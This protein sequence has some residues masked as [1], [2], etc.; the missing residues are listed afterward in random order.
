MRK[1]TSR[2]KALLSITAGAAAGVSAQTSW[3][4]PFAR[5]WRDSFL[6]HWKVTKDYTLAV[7]DAM[8]A[9]GFRF[10]PTDVQRT[11]AEQL[12]HLGRANAAYMTAFGLLESPKPP[13][14][15]DREATR[16]YLAATFDYVSDVLNKMA[17]TD[18][19]RSDLKFNAKIKPHS[20]TD[21]FMRAY[22]HTAHHRGQ[23]I[24]YLRLK[25]VTP[26][27]WAFEPTAA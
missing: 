26:P 4:N 5:T 18:L 11:F 15:A 6:Q 9:D 22:M 25:G 12:V 13:D 14:S 27:A 1:S 7:L 8:P 16:K 10:K 24:C 17:E 3:S 21:L 23:V 20:G 19:T 2:R